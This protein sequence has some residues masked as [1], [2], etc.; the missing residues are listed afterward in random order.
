M[1]KLQKYF[2]CLS[3]KAIPAPN[4]TIRV[5]TIMNKLITGMYQKHEERCTNKMQLYL[6]LLCETIYYMS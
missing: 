3:Y 5:G 2:K 4:A 6:K 1:I